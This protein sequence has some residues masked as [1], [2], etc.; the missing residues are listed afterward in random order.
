M[1]AST[2]LISDAPNPVTVR[3]CLGLM[4]SGPTGPFKSEMGAL[5]EGLRSRVLVAIVA[6]G[7]YLD[8]KWMECLEMKGLRGGVELRGGKK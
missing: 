1:L 7:R 5:V 4:N 6:L 3:L 8:E 2:L